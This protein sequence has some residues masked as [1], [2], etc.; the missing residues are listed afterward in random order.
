MHLDLGVRDV[1]ENLEV[2]QAKHRVC[3]EVRLRKD[4]HSEDCMS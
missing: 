4:E 2:V 1:R 3:G